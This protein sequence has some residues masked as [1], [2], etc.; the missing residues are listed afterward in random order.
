MIFRDPFESLNPHIP[1]R[2]LRDQSSPMGS[3][4]LS[5]AR[6]R[7]G[8]LLEGVGLYVSMAGSFSARVFR[9]PAR[10]VSCLGNCQREALIY[11]NNKGTGYIF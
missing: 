4:Q 8:E 10:H 7:V 6:Q 3:R 5:Q 2:R 9:R 1:A 11:S